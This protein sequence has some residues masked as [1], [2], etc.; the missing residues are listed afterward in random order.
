M[1]LMMK[2]ILTTYLVALCVL[3]T[4]ITNSV[5]AD[6]SISVERGHWYVSVTGNDTGPGT[7]SKP[8]RTIGRAVRQMKAGETCFLRGGTYHETVVLQSIQGRPGEPLTFIPYKN[9]KVVLDG[10]RPIQTKW[11]R[12]K[13]HIYKTRIDK[14][15][16][17][18]FLNGKSMC[19][20]RWPNGNWDDGSV[21]DKTKSLAWPEK[22][23]SNF[24]THYNAG[25]KLL[26]CSLTG[27]VIVVNSGSFRT[28]ASRVKQH[29]PGSDHFS[30]DL[31]G[32]GRHFDN[33]PVEKHGYF[34]ERKLGLLDCPGE[35]YL[36]KE[37]KV[38]Y[39]WPPE[40]QNP[41]NLEICGKV[42]SY[43]FD[44]T[45][46]SHIELQGLNFFGTTFQFKNCRQVTIRDCHFLYPGYSK[47]MLDDLDAFDITQ[48]VT[49]KEYS[50]AHNKVINCVF[51]YMDGPA[52]KMTGLGNLIENCYIHDVDYS[53][54][55]EG[56]WTIN[57]V[58][59]PEL[60]FRRNTVHTTGASEL[61]KSGVR[62]IIEFND[63][64]RSGF[65]QNDGS[66]I[67]VSVKSQKNTIVRYNWVHDTVKQ[68]I[69]FDNSNK[70][71]SQW[72]QGCRA[73]HNVAWKTDRIY[74]KGD[75]HFIHNNLAFDN[76]KNDLIV[77]TNL[78]IN[79]RNFKT[80]T[81]NNI[82]G[83]FSGHRRKP[84]IKYPVP[85][86]VE[87]NWTAD[88]Q[89]C[90]IRTQLKDPDNLDF[91]PKANSELI[92]VGGFM[93]GYDFSYQGSK[94]DIGPYEYGNS[95]YWIPGRQLAKASRPIPPDGAVAVKTDADLMW[96]SAHKSQKHH[97]YWGDDRKKV[98][99]ADPKSSVYRGFQKT[100]I[101]SPDKLER[102][103]T[104]YWRI[105]AEVDG[106][107]KKSDIWSFTVL[108]SN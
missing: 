11:S 45:D 97:I 36:D 3:G 42:Q 91:R 17:Q 106:E 59:S 63:L 18:L 44:A 1:T 66:L 33:Y 74:F 78:E 73:H 7:L 53:C 37:S 72:G 104:Y 69:R 29:Y 107:L 48:M 54:T 61:F 87:R 85:G 20:A 10:T 92:D 14:P 50:P 49:S 43:A 65:L 98:E 103:K 105:D 15:I 77:S 2:P 27:A 101:F 35:W 94:P 71:G 55:Y 40:N 52:I 22:E 19:S 76:H 68:G 81:R 47:R 62:N 64:S 46:S 21:W 80:V 88:M 9:E 100:N 57:T 96:L 84:A 56:G 16:W 5:H 31:T 26:D 67:Q 6:S 51:E 4:G 93:E 30:Y 39:L 79:G 12:Y 60:I 90:D 83:T 99:K 38:L 23:K 41:N 75:R 8:F 13:G 95:H 102:G 34:L 32:V 70:P 86:I 24:G 82:A 25:L 89:K 108:E 58:N 28:Y